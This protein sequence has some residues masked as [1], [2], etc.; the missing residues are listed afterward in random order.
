[1]IIEGFKA[2][3]R[4]LM[5]LCLMC[6][7]SATKACEKPWSY[8]PDGVLPIFWRVVYWTTQFLTWSGPHVPLTHEHA[9]TLKLLP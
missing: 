6:V 1:M 2:A 9:V 5:A 7:C 4:H 3:V 8:I